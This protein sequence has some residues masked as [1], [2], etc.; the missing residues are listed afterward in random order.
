MSGK[1]RSVLSFVAQMLRIRQGWISEV[2]LMPNFLHSVQ[3]QP[4]QYGSILYL[5]QWYYRHI[6]EDF[7][8]MSDFEI[9]DLV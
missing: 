6:V 1:R 2:A 5:Y 8:Q 3:P 7:K 9:L 4:D